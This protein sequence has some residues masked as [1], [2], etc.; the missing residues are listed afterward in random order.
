MFRSPTLSFMLSVSLST[1]PTVGMGTPTSGGPCRDP[2]GGRASRTSPLTCT[3]LRLSADVATDGKQIYLLDAEV[4]AGMGVYLTGYRYNGSP[5]LDTLPEGSGR[6]RIYCGCQPLKRTSAPD[7]DGVLRTRYYF[8]IP[9]NA[10]SGVYGVKLVPKG[11]P[12][13]VPS[14]DPAGCENCQHPDLYVV[15]SYIVSSL[16]RLVINGNS[17][18]DGD[19]P[20]ELSFVF[21]S[22][23]GVPAGGA[24][25]PAV[26]THGAWPGGPKG[27][28]H[29]TNADHTEAQPHLPLFV[30]KEALMNYEECLEESRGLPAELEPT[31]RGQCEAQR[32]SGGYSGQFKVTFGG[33]EVD[34]AA[35]P[36][37]GYLGGA[38]VAGTTCYF[39]GGCAAV[40][41]ATEAASLGKAVSA[42]INK[43]L[44]DDD[45]RLGVA[46]AVFHH[47]TSDFQWDGVGLTGPNK[48]TIGRE[49]GKGDIDTYLFTRRTGAPRILS[50]SVRLK[51]LRVRKGYEEGTCSEPNDVFL[52]ARVFLPKT[53]A[54]AF[55]AS[56]RYPD[57]GT[58]PIHTGQDTVFPGGG[59]TLALE[60]FGQNGSDPTYAPESP[61]LY[62]ELAAWEDDK[63]KDLM[64]LAGET[65]YLEDLVSNPLD[66]EQAKEGYF[67]RRVRRQFT[68]TAHGYTGSDRHCGYPSTYLHEPQWTPSAEQGEVTFTYEV[69]VTWL[70][71]L[72]R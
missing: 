37:Y 2:V 18:D 4:E 45:D 48:L 32:A 23:S 53:S 6:E 11:A 35:S 17:E 33:T 70:K 13:G 67:T 59:L 71:A 25:G 68:T 34:G 39:T 46:E 36:W 55:P 56:T 9:M 42:G 28:G 44:T 47:L 3:T 72:S 38:L 15:P 20:A 29:L 30:G 12:C 8:T 5:P 60:D 1:I 64:G 43:A 66:G 65:V 41:G 40:A 21:E 57:S 22:M 7:P 10:P 51:S 62:I 58:W 31:A 49:D 69:D 52:M 19:N 50:Y 26:E 63:E 24:T 14:T 61:L 27:A 54:I 16:D